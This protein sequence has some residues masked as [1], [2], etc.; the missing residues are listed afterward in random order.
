MQRWCEEALIRGLT[1]DANGEYVI[2]SSVKE[3]YTSNR[4][5]GDAIYTSI[6]KATMNG[7]DVCA[8]L[9]KLEEVEFDKYVDELLSAGVIGTY[10][11]QDT[12][13]QYFC[14][15]LKSSEFSK[16]GKNKIMR[17]LDTIIPDVNISAIKIM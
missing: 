9:Y 14:H 13:I 3:P 11:S 8:R 10:V 4:S 1:Q 7:F 6:V 15:T 5:K 16:L 2:P 17:F 12:G